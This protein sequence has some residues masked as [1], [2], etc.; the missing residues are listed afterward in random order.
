ME[1]NSMT[2]VID[3]SYTIG[4]KR[5]AE[6]EIEPTWLDS[7]SQ[8]ASRKHFQGIHN[9]TAEVHLQLSWKAAE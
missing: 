4:K 1:K 2:Q 6:N 5:R 8:K 3:D 7:Q 9:R